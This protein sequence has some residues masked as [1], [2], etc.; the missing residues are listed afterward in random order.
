M[1]AIGDV[2]AAGDVYTG[3]SEHF[4]FLDQGNGIDDHTHADDG[5]LPGT[6]NAAGDELQDVLVFSDDDGVAG[7][8]ASGNTNDVVERAGEIIHNFAFA[9]VTPLRADHDDRFHALPFLRLRA[10]AEPGFRA[11]G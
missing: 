10:F 4:D 6:Q 9:F 11:S 3:L 8:M 1:S 2:Q 7:I 5:V